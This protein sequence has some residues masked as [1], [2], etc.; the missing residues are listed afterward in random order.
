MIVSGYF[1]NLALVGLDPCDDWKD[2][3]HDPQ[4][5]QRGNANNGKDD[6]KTQK[7]GD[8]RIDEVRD[9]P[10]HRVLSMHVQS[11]QVSLLELPDQDRG[12]KSHGRHKGTRQDRKMQ[13][14]RPLPRFLFL[15]RGTQQDWF[16]GSG[17]NPG[18]PAED[19]GLGRGEFL[20]VNRTRLTELLQLLNFICDTHGILQGIDRRIGFQPVATDCYRRIGFQPVATDCKSILP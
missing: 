7:Q 3:S 9:D 19:P 11:R 15:C 8:R 2:Q 4:S 16:L 6:R 10:I 1:Q 17:L 18:R 13:S 14:E 12:E 20:V 5:D